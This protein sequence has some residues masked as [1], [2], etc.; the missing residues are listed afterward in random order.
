MNELGC[1]ATTCNGSLPL[2]T[3]TTRGRARDLSYLLTDSLGSIQNYYWI[4]DH[5]D[6]AN[7]FWEDTT[8]QE[9]RLRQM[10]STEY[11]FFVKDDY[12]I[13]RDLTLNLGLRYEYYSPAYLKSGLTSTMIDQGN[14]LFGAN[15]N[16]AAG[17]QL[18]DNWLSPGNL[19]LAGYGNSGNLR[20]ELGVTNPNGLPA[21]TCDPQYMTNVEFVGP[22]SPNTKKTV[23]P[24]D[25]NNFGPA[26]GFSW[27]LPWLGAGKTTIRGGYSI[28]FSRVNVSEGTLASAL[29]SVSEPITAFG[30]SAGVTNA[31]AAI[32]ATRAVSVTDLPTLVPLNIPVNAPGQAIPIYTRSASV[33]A[34]DPNFVT[35]YTQNLNL[36][37]TRSL[38]RL[39]TLDVRYVGTLARKQSGSL[40]LNTSTVTITRSCSRHLMRRAGAR[41]RNCSMTC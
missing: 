37:V 4:D 15:R 18:F 24:R 5:S 38:S 6:L 9:N 27:N 8:T 39:M 29:G 13:K 17:G 31:I 30:A 32:A 40:N 35:P 7:G 34:Y 28:Q 21:S 16:L 22:N 36:S 14:G 26:V 20:C 1:H 25:R 19:Y 23:I 2:F 10:Y 33:Q 3:T 11:A 41:T 12:R